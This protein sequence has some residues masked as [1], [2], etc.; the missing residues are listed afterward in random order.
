MRAGHQ[1]L[2]QANRP[3]R[4]DHHALEPN[5]R[6]LFSVPGRSR[7]GRQPHRCL[8][9]RHHLAGPAGQTFGGFKGIHSAGG[10]PAPLPGHRDQQ[11][12]RRPAGGDALVH[13][14]GRALLPQGFA[15]EIRLAGP[16][17]LVGAG[18]YGALHSTART[19]DRRP[20]GALGLRLSG[21]GLRGFELQRPRMDRL[22]RRRLLGRDRRNHQGRQ[23]ASHHGGRAGGEL[24]RHRRAASG[25][26]LQRG[27]RPAKLPAR[28][29]RFHAQLAL[30]LG[31]AQRQGQPGG[32]Q[33]RRGSAA[34]GRP[35]GL[36][37]QRAGRL[38]VGRIQVFQKSGDSG[39][40]GAVFDR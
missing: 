19:P 11:H 10:N 28:Q 38:A 27:R 24:D 7:R 30:R 37:R 33:D 15:G 8:S 39:R 3:P 5:Q 2:G 18:G 17:R 23:P 4:H 12:G 32:R 35:Q 29:R 26:V 6:T 34:Q 9:D 20:T 21:R 31:V 16:S 40:T 25:A 13:R 22:L 36:A 1:R 14:R